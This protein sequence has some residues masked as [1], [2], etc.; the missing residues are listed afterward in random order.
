MVV[1]GH[2]ACRPRRFKK[3]FCL[4]D[5]GKS[6]VAKSIEDF[7]RHELTQTMLVD[8]DQQIVEGR[9][10]QRCMDQ[11]EISHKDGASS[12]GLLDFEQELTSRHTTIASRMVETMCPEFN[13]AS[14]KRNDEK[15]IRGFP[16]ES[17]ENCYLLAKPA[18]FA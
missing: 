3:K 16:M 7:N 15:Y 9:L 1:R 10:H 2:L 8:L 17:K 13:G 4:E 18:T 11:L 5:S 6:I 12:F 14:M